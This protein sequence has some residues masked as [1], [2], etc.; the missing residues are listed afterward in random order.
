MAGRWKRSR[1]DAGSMLATVI[2]IAGG[3]G[4]SCFICL[5]DASQFGSWMLGGIL[6]GALLAIALVVRYRYG[7][8]S[9]SGLTFWYSAHSNPND[10]GIAAQYRPRLVQTRGA[11]NTVGP[12]MPITAEKARELQVTSSKTWVPARAVCR[13]RRD[14]K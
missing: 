4:L 14:A 13:E 2:V 12:N 5:L 3:A 8:A 6:G 9:S 11:E 1:D 10:D 7:R